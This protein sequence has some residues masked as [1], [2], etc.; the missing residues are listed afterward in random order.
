MK[1]ALSKEKPTTMAEV[2]T[3]M[4]RIWDNLTPEYLSRLFDSMPRRMQ[5]VIDSK[6]GPTK[7]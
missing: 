2:K 7:Y 4:Q 3:V 5:A 6:G 1:R